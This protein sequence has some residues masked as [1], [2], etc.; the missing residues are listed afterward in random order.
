[1][2]TLWEGPYLLNLICL[3]LCSLELLKSLS[4]SSLISN[5]LQSNIGYLLM[6]LNKLNKMWRNQLINRYKSNGKLVVG[7]L[8]WEAF[9]GCLLELTLKVSP[10]VLRKLCHEGGVGRELDL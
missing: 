8:G 6:H 7:W 3:P 9:K 2:K 4:I 5:S 1:M 10:E